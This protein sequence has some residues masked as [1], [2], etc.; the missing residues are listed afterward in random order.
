MLSFVFYTSST[1]IAA[2]HNLALIV[3]F[4]SA[5]YTI[6][7]LASNIFS[8]QTNKYLLLGLPFAVT[9]SFLYVFSF[10]FFL[11]FSYPYLATLYK[12][13]TV[14]KPFVVTMGVQS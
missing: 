5:L 13:C 11:R 1:N 9:S 10:F 3:L 14:F 8:I 7:F 2:E 6:G 12:K 4:V